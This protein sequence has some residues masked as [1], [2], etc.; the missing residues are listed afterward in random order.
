MSAAPQTYYAECPDPK[1]GL[2]FPIDLETHSGKYCPRCGALLT[3][4]AFE[5]QHLRIAEMAAPTRQIFGLLDN[6]RSAYNVG[7]IFRT[8]DGAGMRGLYLCGI[9]PT[10]LS[11]PAVAK[12]A[13]GAESALSWEYASN[14]RLLAE[15]LIG[16][17]FML[18]ALETGAQS[19][20]LF[21]L[22]EELAGRQKVVLL[23]GS[24]PYGVDPALMALSEMVAFLPMR[25]VKHS[26]NVAVAFGVAAYFL[27][28]CS[29]E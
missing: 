17:G 4:F 29:A 24:E 12:T 22:R 8:A 7:A 26:L 13:L 18:L 25:G 23:V 1:C 20:P 11:N 6:V 14:A 10:P 9:T 27:S 2:R 5:Q 19:K 28:Q 3:I 15:Q 16:D 21:D